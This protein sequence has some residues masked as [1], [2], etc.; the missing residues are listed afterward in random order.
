MNFRTGFVFMLCVALASVTLSGCGSNKKKR[1]AFPIKGT[2]TVDGAPVPMIQVNFV[3]QEFMEA[4]V[5]E[6]LATGYT[7]DQGAV[8][9]TTNKYNDGI[10]AGEYTLTFVFGEMNLLAG[11][12]EG[13]DKFKGKYSN[14]AKSTFKLTV[15]P[16]ESNDF[17]AVNL[18][19]K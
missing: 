18:T 19:T 9:I 6:P 3:S 16:N 11:R 14:A 5:Y 17:G 12:Y 1:T 8:S 4:K 2:V 15:G 7:D 10:P 13:Q